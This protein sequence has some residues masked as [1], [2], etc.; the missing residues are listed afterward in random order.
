M[1]NNYLSEIDVPIENHEARQITRED[2][3]QADLILVMERNHLRI[4]EEL[5]PGAEKKVELL[6]RYISTDQIVDDII[7]PYGRS[8]YHYRLAQSQITLAIRSLIKRLLSE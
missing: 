6:G 3:D 7:D 1:I 4:I 2:V 5:W 8:P